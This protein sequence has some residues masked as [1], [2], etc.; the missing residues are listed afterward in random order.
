[1]KRFLYNKLWHVLIVL[2]TVVVISVAAYDYMIMT[3]PEGLKVIDIQQEADCVHYILDAAIMKVDIALPQGMTIQ[4][5]DYIPIVDKMAPVLNRGFIILG[6]AVAVTVTFAVWELCMLGDRLKKR[7]SMLCGRHVV[8]AVDSYSH[9][10]GPFYM[11]VVEADGT[12]YHYK[13]P[14]TKKEAAKFPIGTPV[15][16]YLGGRK[17]TWI[18]L[19]KPC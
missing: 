5:G 15:L 6:I 4:I 17:N 2:V 12:K 9:Y 18:D 1:M 19:S 14:L 7:S 13:Y 16:T 8:G 3:K 10:M 11:M